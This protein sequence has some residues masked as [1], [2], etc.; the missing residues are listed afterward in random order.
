MYSEIVKNLVID[1][2]MAQVAESPA[3]ESLVGKILWYK[4]NAPNTRY[5]WNEHMA[6]WIP[7]FGISTDFRTPEASPTVPF[8]AYYDGSAMGVLEY[9]PS[10]STLSDALYVAEHPGLIAPNASYPYYRVTLFGND[11]AMIGYQIVL[12]GPNQYLLIDE[13]TTQLSNKQPLPFNLYG[14]QQTKD[15]GGH[16]IYVMKKANWNP[17]NVN[18]PEILVTNMG[19]DKS[20]YDEWFQYPLILRY[21][22]NDSK[23]TGGELSP[24]FLSPDGQFQETNPDLFYFETQPANPHL[25]SLLSADAIRMFDLSVQADILSLYPQINKPFNAD[26]NPGS[27]LIGSLPSELSNMILYTGV[28]QFYV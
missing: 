10:S 15:K 3:I 8:D 14:I 21:I 17:T 11:K 23:V 12:T 22:A 24:L 9:I 1:P 7:V 27:Y 2:T 19:F 25:A 5:I 28:H 20:A 16:I 4:D 26:T 18:S 13:N 6:A